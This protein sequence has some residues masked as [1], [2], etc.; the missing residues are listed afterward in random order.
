MR[1]FV[2]ECGSRVSASNLRAVTVI[3]LWISSPFFQC[4]LGTFLYSCILLFVF[5]LWLFLACLGNFLATGGRYWFLRLFLGGFDRVLGVFRVS[6]APLHLL[7][8]SDPSLG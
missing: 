7:W 2:C 6:V 4:T 5:A 3:A 8:V 1:I